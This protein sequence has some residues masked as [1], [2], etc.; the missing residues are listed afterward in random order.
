MCA[1]F[2]AL[3]VFERDVKSDDTAGKEI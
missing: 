1:G 2:Y 3:R